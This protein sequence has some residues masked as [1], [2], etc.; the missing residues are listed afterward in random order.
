[1]LKISEVGSHLELL[2]LLHGSKWSSPGSNS[3]ILYADIAK[4]ALKVV[5]LLVY[6]VIAF[7]ICVFI[8]IIIGVIFFVLTFK[9]FFLVFT[10]FLFLLL[11][12]L[13]FAFFLLF[14]GRAC[15]IQLL[16]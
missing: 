2:N 6:D 4:I 8:I 15:H 5:L 16:K 7:F 9:L 10:V 11:I 3:A 12:P 14:I 13:G 1:L